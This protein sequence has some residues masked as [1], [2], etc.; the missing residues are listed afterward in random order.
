MYLTP[1]QK[2]IFLYIQSYIKRNNVSPTYDDIRKRFGFS[3]FNSVFKH[4]K[5]LE[6]KGVIYIRPKNKKRAI[7]LVDHG[8]PAV[9][10]RL[11]G[12]I[13]AG[14]PIEAIEDVENISIP[15]ELLG[16]GENF[17]LKVKGDSM[18]YDGIHDGD[19]VIIKKRNFAENNEMV[20]ALIDN[21]ATLKRFYKR[22]SW[23]ELRPANPSMKPIKIKSGNFKILGVVVGLIRMY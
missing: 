12:T 6:D 1:R 20:A 14:E 23:V 8:A 2:E 13:A 4:M 9:N 22:K 5:Q 15:R 17:C 7:T 10:V 21:E 3:S 11:L 18:I 19:I 16:K